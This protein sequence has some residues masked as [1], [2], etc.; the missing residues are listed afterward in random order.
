MTFNDLDPTAQR[1][2]NECRGQLLSTYGTLGKAWHEGFD[3][4]D[5]GIVDI[6]DFTTACKSALPTLKANQVQTLFHYLLARHGQRSV[7]KENWRSLL[8][9]LSTSQRDSAW[10]EGEDDIAAPLEQE[11]TRSIDTL[12]GFKKMLLAKYGS[13]FAAWKHALDREHNGYVMKQDFCLTCRRLGVKEVASIWRQFLHGTKKDLITLEVLDTETA[14]AWSE[15]YQLLLKASERKGRPCHANSEAG[16]AD[17]DKDTSGPVTKPSLKDGWRKTFDPGNIRRVERPRF[18]EGC[19]K[20]GY[21]KDPG[22]LFDLLRPEPFR[23][24]LVYEDFVTDLNPNKFDVKAAVKD[25][26]LPMKL[27]A[28]EEAT[29][30]SKRELQ[31]PSG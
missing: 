27:A 30:R 8:I 20:L 13:F 15:L 11:E 12:E 7:R 23:E 3:P 31:Q 4:G 17:A 6:T 24:Y 1:F 28:T 29:L 14:D 5:L 25:T 22:R 16:E 9:G 2:I 21:S 10:G 18:Y 26:Y 19:K